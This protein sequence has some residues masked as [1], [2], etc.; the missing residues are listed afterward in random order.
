[1]TPRAKR[2][3]RAALKVSLMGE[4]FFG[5]GHQTSKVP[6]VAFQF[7]ALPILVVLANCVYSFD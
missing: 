1:M 3:N 5:M 2:M 6:V 4:F 7:V